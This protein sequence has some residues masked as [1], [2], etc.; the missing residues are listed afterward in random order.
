[1]VSFR[2]LLESKARIKMLCRQCEETVEGTGCVKRGVCGKTEELARSQDTLVGTLVELASSGRTGEEVDETIVDGLFMTLSNT[3]FNRKAVDAQTERARR[4]IGKDVE[5]R[6]GGIL[7]LDRDTDLRSLKELLLL[8]LKG[9]AAYYHHARV[10]GERDDSVTG[11]IR[12][13][14]ASLAEDLDADRLVALNMECGK[15]G[16]ACLA[17]LDKANTGRYG[18]PEI[19]QVR[20]GVGRN[21]GILVTGHDLKDLEDILEQT[22]GTG[23]DVYTHGEMLPASSYPAFKRYDNLVGNYGGAWYRQRDE[24]GPCFGAFTSRT[25]SSASSRHRPFSFSD[26]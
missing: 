18:S 2:N 1:M 8:G 13:G 14:M 3:N 12:K 7:S 23:I 15:V 21:P 4:L 9:M 5:I 16:A 11:F 10:L 22:R 20:T 24:F 26:L 6:I 17:L 25:V 19:T